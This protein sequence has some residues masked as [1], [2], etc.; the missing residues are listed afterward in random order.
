M[1]R[2][3][4]MN[5]IVKYVLSIRSNRR[6]LKEHQMID[7]IETIKRKG[8]TIFEIM[9]LIEKHIPTCKLRK[10][11][12][13]D[14]EDEVYFRKTCTIGF[15]NDDQYTHAQLIDLANISTRTFEKTII[16]YFV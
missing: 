6:K 14:N 10:L 5:V 8:D 9:K 3:N 12:Y 11:I 2:Q 7:S 13:K 4:I 15:W 1:D 16:N